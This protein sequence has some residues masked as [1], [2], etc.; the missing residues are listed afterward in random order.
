MFVVAVAKI[1][2]IIELLHDCYNVLMQFNNKAIIDYCNIAIRKY[3]KWASLSLNPA[4]GF[5][6][7]RLHLGITIEQ[8]RGF[9]SRLA[10]PL[11][12]PRAVTLWKAHASMAF[13]SLNP[14]LAFGLWLWYIGRKDKFASERRP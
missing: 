14:A 12:L 3:Y 8:A 6:E 2:I 5:A 11:A 7:C 13:L 1:H 4:L 10:L 9:C